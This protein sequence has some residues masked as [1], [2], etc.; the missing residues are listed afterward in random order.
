MNIEA[1]IL[2][3]IMPKE[4]NNISKRSYIMSKSTLPGMQRWVSICKLL[5]VPQYINRSKNKNH[6]IIS[7]EAEK[8][9]Q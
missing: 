5:S 7:I 4:F 6:L 3:K 8:S 2:K 1:K 9:L